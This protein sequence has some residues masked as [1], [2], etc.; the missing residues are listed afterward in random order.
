[1]AVPPALPL[2][3]RKSFFS[4]M[5]RAAQRSDRAGGEAFQTTG[6]A[7]R[8]GEDRMLAKTG[9][10]QREET[11]GAGGDATATTAAACGI[12]F[13]VRILIDGNSPLF[14]SWHL[15]YS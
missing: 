11:L 8:G 2:K 15:S 13:G 10:L 7:L 4:G 12:D 14:S 3:G 9:D 5:L 1:M 6:A